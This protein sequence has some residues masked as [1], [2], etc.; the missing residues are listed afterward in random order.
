[1]NNFLIRLQR[2][3]VSVHYGIP[4]T[5]FSKIGIPIHPHYVP[6]Q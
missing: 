2:Y 6:I 1:M 4:A 3:E 5:N